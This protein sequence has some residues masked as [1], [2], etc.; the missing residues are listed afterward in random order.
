M[1]LALT[2]ALFFSLAAGICVSAFMKDS[3]KAMGN[4]LF[5]LLFLVAVVPSLPSLLSLAHIGLRWDGLLLVSPVCPFLFARESL[6]FSSSSKFW[7]SLCASHLLAW[8]LLALASWSLPWLW[9]TESLRGGNA[10][11]FSFGRPFGARTNRRSIRVGAKNPIFWLLAFRSGLGRLPW[12]LLCAWTTF[13]VCVTWNN[14]GDAGWVYYSAKVCGFIFK[15]LIATETCRFF[16]EARRTGALELLL[17]TPLKNEDLLRGQTLAL[18]RAFLWPLLFF[19][20][21]GCFPL[22]IQITNT[23]ANTGSSRFAPLVA[24][25]TT[26]GAAFA[27]FIFG[28]VADVFAVIWFGRWL[29]LTARNPTYAAPLT[30]LIVLILPSVAFCGDLVADFVFIVWGTSSLS[31]GVRQVFA[32]QQA[33]LNVRPHQPGCPCAVCQRLPKA[34]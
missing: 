10:R 20:V 17:C 22:A 11:G 12:F 16:A 26:A 7:Y 29:A 19:V 30:I 28:F 32:K 8:A 33:R 2:N 4:T 21:V 34:A 3:Q 14:P 27:W 9:R 18:K 13:V 5:L 31:Q 23:L 25:I 24:E 6:F 15:M 1:V